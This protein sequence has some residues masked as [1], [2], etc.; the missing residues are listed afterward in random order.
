MI[1]RDALGDD[2]GPA[3]VLID[4]SEHARVSGDLAR[5]WGRGRFRVVDP[6]DTV[7]SAIYRHDDGWP[8][9]DRAPDVDSHT[10]RPVAF[11]EMELGTAQAIWTQSIEKMADLGPL[12]Q[13]IVACHFVAMRRDGERAV[14]PDGA[15]FVRTFQTHIWSMRRTCR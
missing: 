13:Y 5:A 12:A 6:R 8:A 15:E 10:G 3:W 4:Q 2:G 9:Y 14:T 1:R 11:T 7:V